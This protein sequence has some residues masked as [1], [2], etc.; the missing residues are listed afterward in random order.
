MKHVLIA[1]TAL[2]LT[3]PA[4][5]QTTVTTTTG[6]A[7]AQ[8][9]IAPEQRTKIKTYVTSQKIAPVTVKEKLVIGA[10]VPTDVKLV[11]VP[12]DW[13]PGVTKYKY[14]YADNHV[15]LVE[16]SSRKVIQIID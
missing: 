2:A 5:A 16:P 9:T 6:V 13:G 15:V 7:N 1:I 4:L 12:A 14:V 3:T 8:I 10:T 11:A